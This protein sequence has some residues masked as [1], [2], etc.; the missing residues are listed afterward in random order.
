MSNGSCMKEIT[1]R[2]ITG[3]KRF[4][5]NDVPKDLSMAEF[6]R[7]VLDNTDLPQHES[8]SQQRI[9]Y[10]ARLEREGRYLNPEENVGVLQE[11]DEIVL[12][13][14]VDAG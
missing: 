13:P 7:G 3:Q 8:S 10:R 11:K 1:V 2:D 12:Q 5:L 4:A 14:N 6:V 9:M